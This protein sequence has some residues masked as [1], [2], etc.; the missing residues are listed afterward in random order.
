MKCLNIV[1]YYNNFQEIKLY[2]K[3]CLKNSVNVDIAVV[4]NSDKERKL[5]E[6]EKIAS[7]YASRLKI[8]NFGENVGYLN[9][10]LKIIKNETFDEYEYYILSNTDIKYETPNFYEKLV[11]TKYDSCVG[12]IAPSVYSQNTKSFSNP[13]YKNRVSKRKFQVLSLIF[14]I[15]V[16][17][18]IYLKLAEMKS[19]THRS[20][21]EEESCYV[22][23][24][25]GCFMIFTKDFIQSIRGY[26]YGVTL[27]SEEAC[28]GELLL[29][30]DKKCYFDNE[31]RVQ[32]FE[33]TV[34]GKI[35]YKVRFKYWKNSIDYILREFY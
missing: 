18:K 5:N 1:V 2:I 7:K 35:N 4:V 14:S 33:S 16:L 17:G 31:L 23:S 29:K 30:S 24:P 12:C 25:H 9:S 10:L 27:Y 20:N 19:K 28:I 34:T 21:V 11:L 32:H 3:E 22:Y 8:Y 13:H 26:I 15:P 6:M